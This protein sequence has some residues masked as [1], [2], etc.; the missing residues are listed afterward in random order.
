MDIGHSSGG[1]LER[2]LFYADFSEEARCAF[3]FAAKLAALRP[4]TV[5][6]LL[7]VIPEPEGQF[8]KSYLYEV[9]GVDEKARRDIQ[10]KIDEEYGARSPAC[11]DLRT[12][13]RIGNE[14]A[15]ILDVAREK[16]VDL[17]VIGRPRPNTLNRALSGH[18]V[19]WVVR[20]APCPVLVVPR[21]V[22]PNRP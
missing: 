9:D 6:Y 5:L 1:L 22:K 16:E 10:A 21:E 2:I 3:E 8:W 4:G 12:E 15:E 19:E 20:K 13:V 14:C 11:S 18:L 17:I 7:H